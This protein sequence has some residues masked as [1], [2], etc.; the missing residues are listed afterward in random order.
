MKMLSWVLENIPS[1]PLSV[2]FQALE[3]TLETAHHECG[4]GIA[5]EGFIEALL[6]N[7][8]QEGLLSFRSKGGDTFWSLA[9]Q[10][11][12]PWVLQKLVS[13]APPGALLPDE[14]G[15][16]PLHAAAKA[17]S[18]SL[19]K[20]SEVHRK[21]VENVTFLLE[22]GCRPDARN[23]KGSRPMDYQVNAET[24]MMYERCLIRNETERDFSLKRT[25]RI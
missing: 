2:R 22:C 3:K 24:R 16:T 12:F 1:I 20:N 18:S 14:N 8:A 10:G 9:A 13:I 4:S 17:L 5:T 7:T 11:R 25:P 23:A 15:S 19:K 21:L 6:E